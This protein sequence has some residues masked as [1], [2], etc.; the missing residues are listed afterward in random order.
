MAIL[1]TAKPPPYRKTAGSSTPATAKGLR[2]FL[3]PYDELA[4]AKDECRNKAEVVGY[5]WKR[6]AVSSRIYNFK[7]VSHFRYDHLFRKGGW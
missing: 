5:G 3:N 7:P 4:S 6:H 2:N 1:L